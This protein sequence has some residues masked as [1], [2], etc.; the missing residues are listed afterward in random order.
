MFK[1]LEICKLLNLL[2]DMKFTLSINWYCWCDYT[3][4]SHLDVRTCCMF[5]FYAI[6]RW[7]WSVN[8]LNK[9]VISGCTSA[10]EYLKTIRKL[11]YSLYN[12]CWSTFVVGGLF[13]FLQ[14]LFEFKVCKSMHHHTIQINQPTRCSNLSS[15]LLDIYV[16]LNVSGI[17]TPI[18]RSSTTA[19]A[20]SGFTFRAWW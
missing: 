17:L 20:A 11:F 7:T 15:L 1:L 6:L 5:Q 12:M 19:L 2:G 10:F 13:L 9:A 18:I 3:N 4:F 8:K 14:P 16:Q